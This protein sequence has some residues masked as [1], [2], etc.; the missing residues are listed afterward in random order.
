MLHHMMELKGRFS[1]KLLK[2]ARFADLYFDPSGAFALVEPNRLTG[3]V[4]ALA[5]PPRARPS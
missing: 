5:R 4:R 2:R 1:A 3:A